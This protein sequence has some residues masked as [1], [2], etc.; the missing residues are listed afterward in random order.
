MIKW[1]FENVYTDIVSY[2]RLYFKKQYLA[3]RKDME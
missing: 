2:V 3:K 1:N